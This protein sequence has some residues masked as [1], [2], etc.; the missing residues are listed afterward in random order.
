MRQS[1]VLVLDL[2]GTLYPAANR[3]TEL[4][5]TR[6]E[7]FLA[8]WA[9]LNPGELTALE[10]ERPSIFDALD[11]LGISRDRW[12]RA[13]YTGLPYT[14]FLRPDSVLRSVLA[15]VPARRIVVTMAPARHAQDVVA[16]LGLTEMIDGLYS[17]FDS[18]YMSKDHI[19]AGL[20]GDG[21]P[22]DFLV[23]GDN[24]RLDLDPAAALRCRCLLVGEPQP[25]RLYP[26]YPTLLAALAAIA[27]SRIGRKL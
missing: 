6:T 1:G 22:A 7:A 19:Y 16:A 3:L 20:I 23:M 4:V 26:T 14:E 25:S 21:D 24:P 27:E 9:G 12:A 11:H 10:L 2:D 5:D 15:G 17:V 18:P 8:E 13:I